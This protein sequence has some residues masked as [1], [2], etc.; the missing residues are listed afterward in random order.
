MSLVGTTARVCAAIA[1]GEEGEVMIPIAGGSQA[2][3]ARAY[4]YDGEFEEGERVLILEEAGRTLYVAKI[5]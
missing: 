2:F 5:G 1:K 4:E 3:P